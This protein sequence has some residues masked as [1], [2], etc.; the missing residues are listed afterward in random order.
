MELKLDDARTMIQKVLKVFESESGIELV[1][2]DE[3]TIHF[4]FGWVFFYQ[5]KE[6]VETSNPD[7]LL[8]GNVPIIVDKYLRDM[9]EVGT[10]RG[11]KYYQERYEKNRD[12]ISEFRQLQSFL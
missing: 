11:I 3:E 1:V 2:L 8:G 7:F 6:F 12:V 4:E 10:R 5:S 9:Y